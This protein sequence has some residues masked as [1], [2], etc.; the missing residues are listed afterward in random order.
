MT[1]DYRALCAELVDILDSGIPAR[2]IRLSP[3]L[4]RARALLAQPVAEGALPLKERP[5]FIAGYKEGLADGRRIIECEEAERPAAAPVPEPQPVAEPV[6]EGSKTPP[7]QQQI[8]D[9]LEAISAAYSAQGWV[10][11]EDFICLFEEVARLAGIVEEGWDASV[12]PN[13][14]KAKARAVLARWGRPTPQPVAVSERLPGPED[15]DDQ[16]RCWLGGH[17]MGRGT[18]T[19]LL[20]YP[21]W[22]KRFPDVHRF[23]LPANALPLPAPE[24]GEV[25]P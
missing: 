12:N 11:N 3:L 22:A 17:Q 1:P 16:G 10:A 20:G 2:R 21:V 19:W 25:Q 23:W 13:D 7:N 8:D 14:T 4:D 15:C 18:P 6:G 9:L 5:D 24:G